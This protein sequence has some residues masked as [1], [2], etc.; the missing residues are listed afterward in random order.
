MK[1]KIIGICICI[2]LI[3]V[4]VL[5]VTGTKNEPEPTIINGALGTGINDEH[6][7]TFGNGA[8]S[9][10]SMQEVTGLPQPITIS[11][12]EGTGGDLGDR[13]GDVLVAGTTAN[14]VN[15]S[16]ASDFQG[17]LYI[18]VE[19]SDGLIFYR[20][21]NN[22]Q[23]WNYWIEFYS[24]EMKNPSLAVGQGNNQNYLFW[25]CSWLGTQILVCRLNLS[26]P[27]DYLYSMNYYN[28]M[29]VANPKIVTDS[30]E[31][32]TWYIYLIFNEGTLVDQDAYQLSFSRSTNY[33]DNFTNPIMLHLYQQWPF[34]DGHT[35]HPDIDYG[36][37]NLFVAFDDYDMYD[38]ERDVYVMNSIN[39]GVSWSSAVKV[40]DIDY[41]DEYDPSVAAVKDLGS[42]KTVLIT[43]T[44]MWS[45]TDNDIL[46]AY[47]QDGGATWHKY[48]VLDNSFDNDTLSDLGT[49]YSQG[50]IHV[51][52]HKNNNIIYRN[53]A[54]LTPT[55]WTSPIIINEG[56]SATQG[57][58]PSIAVNPTQYIDEEAAITWTDFRNAGNANDI[59]FDSRLNQPPNKPATPTG[60]TSRVIGQSGKYFTS[61]TDPDNDQVQ[62]RFDWNASG[63]HQYSGWTTLVNS[64][65][66]VNKTHTWNTAGTYVVKTQARDEH[67]VIS[68]WS[69]GLTVTV[70]EN[71]PPNKPKTPTG[72]TARV[73]GQQ[74]TYWANGTDPDGDKIQ[75]RFDWNASGSHSYSSWTS[76]VNSGTKLSKNH[77]WTT[78]RTYVVKVQSRDEHGAV[79]VWSN[80]LTV[81]VTVNHP[82]NKPQ[83]PTGPTTRLVGQQGTYWANGTDPDGDKIQYR[84]DWNASGSHSY[85][86]WTSLVNSGTKVSKTHAWFIPGTYVVKVQ[87]RDE[88][89][90]K[91]VWSNGLTVIVS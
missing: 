62:Y 4:T 68:V 64:G 18:A 3:A 76:L 37:N 34:Y 15:S 42:D 55:A 29:G 12:S 39:F 33:G 82:P 1:R 80:G 77:T 21:T 58:S 31:W 79:S 67:G 44:R 63:S 69:D 72:P 85:S 11:E 10:G 50:K 40:A 8:E 47:S 53:T 22:G 6:E 66:T 87:S 74:G 36:S 71:H 41:N 46:Y 90:M 91:S 32:S 73:T 17:K 84:F 38:N 57:Y 56:N 5:P 7:T 9:L 19:K 26:D 86:S 49:S 13:G 70:T 28:V 89:G 14:E 83:K 51:V 35:A 43:Y 25:T 2:L 20:S 59:Y 61:T 48:Y 52:Y 54:Y 30:T 75:Y 81:I 88:H 45:S 60:P 24:S 23:S 16:I 27:Y 65:Q 78:P